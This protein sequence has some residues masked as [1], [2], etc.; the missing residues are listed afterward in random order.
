LP[1][2]KKR[3]AIAAT[4]LRKRKSHMLFVFF[5]SKPPLSQAGLWGRGG[6]DG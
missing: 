3:R 2:A 6:G 4:T 5:V 1:T